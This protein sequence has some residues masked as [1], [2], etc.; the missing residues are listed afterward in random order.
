MLDFGILS[1]VSCSIEYS[2]MAPLTPAVIV[3]RGLVFHSAFC[4]LLIN[5]GEITPLSS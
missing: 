1:L 4:M 5:H 3:M 2:R